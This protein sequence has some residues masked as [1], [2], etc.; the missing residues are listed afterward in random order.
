MAIEATTESFHVSIE[1]DNTGEKWFGDFTAKKRLSH[2]DH[3]R[4]DQVR[5]EMLGGATGEPSQRAASTA[6]ILSELTVRL[7][8]APGWWT[9]NDNGL[10]F[11]DDNIIGE[12]YD[13]AMKVEKDAAEAKKKK[14]EKAVEA[15][16]K[17]AEEK[18]AA[19]PT[20]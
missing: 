9:D 20:E 7:T 18:K 2:A 16:R 14:A 19:E 17:E 10:K 13:G 3:L 12:V 8:K 6:M 5:R 4:K 1:G 11:E 15:M